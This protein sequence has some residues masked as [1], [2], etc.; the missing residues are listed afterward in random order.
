M[1]FRSFANQR[2]CLAG[3]DKNRRLHAGFLDNRARSALDEFFSMFA[4]FVLHRGL[5]A[6]KRDE[7]D[8]FDNRQY[9]DGAAGFRGTAGGKAQRDARLDGLVDDDEICAHVFWR[10][11]PLALLCAQAAPRS[12][13]LQA[14]RLTATLACPIGKPKMLRHLPEEDA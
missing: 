12:R 6:A 14:P 7:F 13:F 3:A 4:R 1:L 2:D 8:G 11:C 10:P 9:L 5:N